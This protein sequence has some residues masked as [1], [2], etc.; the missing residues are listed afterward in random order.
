VLLTKFVDPR[1][2]TGVC[3]C[4][5]VCVCVQAHVYVCVFKT[6]LKSSVWK[7]LLQI[8]VTLCFQ[9]VQ[10]ILQQFKFRSM[11]RYCYLLSVIYLV[12]VWV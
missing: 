9:Y 1:N 8:T 5:C 7:W 2:A 4:V 11:T 6:M 12:C 10:Q 3:V